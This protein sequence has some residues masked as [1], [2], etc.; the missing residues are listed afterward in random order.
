MIFHK[1]N[2]NYY[3]NIYSFALFLIKYI[4]YL[5]TKSSMKSDFSVIIRVKN[6]DKHIGYCIQSVIDNLDNPEIIIVDNKSND[7][8]I[9]IVN[10]FKKDKSLKTSDKRYVDIKI[11]NIN[12]YTP[13]KAL[14]LGISKSKNKY[15][16]IISAHCKIISFDKKLTYKKLDEGFAIF[17]NQIPIWNGKRI[18]KKYL[19]TN[20][21]NENKINMYSGDESRYFFHNA[22]SF[23]KKSLLKKFPFNENLVSKEDRYWANDFI[24]LKKKTF[25]MPSNSVEHYY[26]DNGATWKN[27]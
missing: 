8:S 5:R 6:E 24:S 3:K 9:D 2:I 14:N 17:G 15:I 23:F 22:F 11:H 27:I 1:F 20:F 13:G 7:S 16:L 10:H 26:T 19:W 25:Y 21:I 12:T 4:N 18:K